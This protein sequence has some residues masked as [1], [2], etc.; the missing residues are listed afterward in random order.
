ML[1]PNLNEEIARTNFSPSAWNWGENYLA[2]AAVTAGTVQ[3]TPRGVELTADVRRSAHR[4]YRVTIVCDETGACQGDCTCPFETRGG[5]AHC[6]AVLMLW[7]RRP[8]LFSGSEP[9]LSSPATRSMNQKTSQDTDTPAA[10]PATTTAKISPAGGTG[11][12]VAADG[13]ICID[14]DH[15][16]LRAG[17]LQDTLGEY[18]L[19]VS[20]QPYVTLSAL[21]FA[22]ARQHGITTGEVQ[23]ALAEA[24]HG[25]MPAAVI[26]QIDRWTA[27]TDNLHLYDSLCVIEFADDFILHELLRVSGLRHYLVHI[28]SPRVIAIQPKQ[29]NALVADLEARGYMPRVEPV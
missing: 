9:S 26:Q 18:L 28:F 11:L 17:R 21:G 29:V 8:D 4:S 15:A 14:L 2:H 6:A 5:C 27:A 3:R 20:G 24:S 13:T 22:S 16:G 23:T 19:P 25:T 10:G 1:I 12:W 7:C